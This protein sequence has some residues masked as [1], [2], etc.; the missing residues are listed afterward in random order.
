[1]L[2]DTGPCTRGMESSGTPLQKP[3]NFHV[4][5]RFVIYTQLW[6]WY[7]NKK[8]CINIHFLC[9]VVRASVYNLVNETNL[10]HNLFLV[11]YVNLYMFRSSPGLSS[12]GTTVLMQHLVLVI[13]YSWL[14][15]MQSAIQNNDYQVSH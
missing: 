13:P 11:Y 4:L 8:H 10:V 5:P 3:Q 7:H 1:M 12:G 15:G 2:I 9:F 14:S 6:K